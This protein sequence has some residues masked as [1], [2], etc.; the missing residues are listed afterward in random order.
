MSRTVEFLCF[1]EEMIYWLAG[2]NCHFK[3]GLRLDD[4]MMGW[5]LGGRIRYFSSYLNWCSK[6]LHGSARQAYEKCM[7]KEKVSQLFVWVP[8]VHTHCHIG[9]M[10]IQSCHLVIQ[11]LK[12]SIRWIFFVEWSGVV[13][14]C[15]SIALLEFIQ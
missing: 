8:L 12:I 9:W 13:I 15:L 7:W 1:S 3:F 6:V 2:F 11:T 4:G 10:V 5:L 14:F